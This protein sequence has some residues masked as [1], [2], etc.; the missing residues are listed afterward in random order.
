MT[1]SI[2]S[3]PA[4]PLL[5]H[6]T[7]IDKEVPLRSFELLA[8]QYGDIYQLNLITRQSIII[9]SYDLMNEVSNDKRFSKAVVGGLVETRKGLGDGL[10]TAYPGEENWGVAHRLLMPAF[11]TAKVRDMFD[12]MVDIA[13]QMVQK[14]ERF[15][16]LHV[17]DAVEDFTRLAFDTIALCAM[18]Y[19]LNNFYM[20]QSHPF[21]Q[22]MGDFLL[23]SGLRANRPPIMNT[24]MR[25]SS[26]KF[27]ADLNTMNELVD[28]LIQYRKSHPTEK[29]DLLNIM[30]NGVD[31]KT[32]KGLSD[33]NIR[34]NLLTF[35]VAG[36]ETT[37]GLLTFTLY[38]LCKNP[39][40]MRRVR[41]EVDEV[42][43]EG[44]IRVEDISKLKYISACLRETLRL[45]P[46]AAMRAVEA[47][48][49]A[50]L[51][52][53]KYFIPKGSRIGILTAKAQCDPKVWGEDAREYKPERMYGENFEKIPQN[54]WQPFGY[55]MRACIGRP[56]AWQEAHIA[57]A[58]VIQKFDIAMDD[59]SYT[60]EIKQQLTVKP[61]GF[62]CHAIPRNRS[63]SPIAVAPTSTLV[64]LPQV[65]QASSKETEPKVEPKHKLYVAYGSNTGTSQTFAQRIASEAPRR[66]FKASL[67][68][69]DSITDHVPTDGPLVIC[70]ASFEG[71]PADN[72]THFFEW[73]QSLK[74]SE[75]DGVKY[76]VFG[77]GNRDWVRTYQ[78]IPKAIDAILEQRGGKR[79]QERGIGDAQAAEFFEVF[80]DWEAKLWNALA[81][82]YNLQV[83]EDA[84]LVSSIS[85]Q[86]IDVGTTRASILRQ[87]DADLGKVTEN[88]L[89]TS[90]NAPA[91]RHIEFELPEHMTYRAGDYLAI[92]PTNPQR[93]VHR[94]TAR[95]GF[96]PE[97]QI[98]L[99]SSGPT[100]LPVDRPV[101]VSALLSGYVE[102]SQP[103]TTRD[104]RILLSV[105][106]SDATKVALD[107]IQASYSEKVLGK[108]ISVLDILEEHPDIQLPFGTYLEMLPAMRVRQYSISSSPLHN[109][110]R[111]TLTVSVVEA[112]ALSGKA[113]PFLGVASNFLA[114]L[115]A[116]DVVQLAVRA[117]S[118]A[119]HPPE[120]PKIPMVMFAAGSGLSPMRGFLQE[121]AVQK[122]AGREVAKSLLFFGCRSPQEDYLYG[123]S[124]LKEW[125]ELGIVDV[126][127]AFSRSP[128]VSLGLKYI[129]DRVWHDRLDVRNYFDNLG[130]KFFT[131]GS[132]KVAQGIK[133]VLTD[134]IKEA[135]VCTDEDAAALFERAI[136]GRYATDVF[137]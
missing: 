54:S 12:D 103:A 118:A 57:L 25:G 96:S 9:S 108:R 11:S 88:R 67:G 89:L 2:P 101:S 104:L 70:T 15:G 134:I 135:R 93:D 39:E 86:T 52:G 83:A 14:W 111:P 109:P 27:E 5:G 81:T 112:P 13:E 131:C 31:N 44:P 137:E 79:L 47:L 64:G 87:S 21:V 42:L 3:P 16:P 128:E 123:D 61:K 73:V 49:D 126:R 100:S 68:T 7:Q 121:R 120:N 24:L 45:S 117:A 51:S 50:T 74:G 43:G 17:V 46:P 77:C 75:F 136:Q 19:R 82:E 38:Y 36:H 20:E 105:K 122:Q 8:D 106:S 133:K 34:F 76:A 69:L 40:A 29:Q 62:Y 66:G 18:S 98:V 26:A 22:A 114:G 84:A 99:G 41:E 85:I 94:V 132:G 91:K 92:L 48:E 60:L 130:A 71:E 35:L 58:M 113:E 55:G 4:L 72:A 53:S 37:S 125:Q 56:F 95:F 127:P 65:S 78:R 90:P 23:E 63:S 102:L 115:R 116:G 28:E 97:Q 33:E 59:P 110:Q 32:G 80:D 1:T 107:S 124:D 119:F 10:F 6:I 30:L 129:Q